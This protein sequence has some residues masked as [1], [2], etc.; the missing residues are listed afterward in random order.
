MDHR[1]HH[2]AFLKSD[3]MQEGRLRTVT[4]KVSLLNPFSGDGQS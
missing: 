4:L 3:K 2:M 1:V